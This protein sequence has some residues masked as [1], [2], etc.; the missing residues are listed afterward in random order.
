MARK[1]W[2]THTI[3]RFIVLVHSG[4]L[5][6]PSL[7]GHIPM[8]ARLLGMTQAALYERQRAL[9]RAG[10]LDQ[11]KGRGPGSGVRLD[12]SSLA[13]LL[14]CVLAAGNLTDSEARVRA[15]QSALPIGQDRCPYTAMWTFMG[16]LMVILVS[17][18]AR[19]IEISVS[20]TADRASFKYRDLAGNV[21]VSEFAGTRRTEP[22]IAVLATLS[23]SPLQIIARDVHLEFGIAR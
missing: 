2:W 20:R 5:M 9:V 3:S 15:I 21:K 19:V 23:H 18:S 12:A 11:S 22:G 16:A 4:S 1:R 14:I 10:L 17:M 8:L 6:M 7:K 13:V